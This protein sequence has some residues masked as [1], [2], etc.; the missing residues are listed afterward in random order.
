MMDSWKISTH[1]INSSFDVLDLW[2]FSRK[3]VR[4]QTVNGR[5]VKLNKFESRLNSREL[6]NHCVKLSP[7]HVYMSVLNWL[8][9]ERVGRKTK[10]NYAVPIGGE[11]VI[12]VDSHVIHRYHRHDCS[13]LWG[14]CR[15]C[16]EISKALTISACDTIEWYYSKIA[17]V[18]SGKRGFHIHVLDFDYRD[19]TNFNERDPIKTHE[20]ARYRFSKVISLQTYVFDRAHFTL[21]VDPVGVISVP[22]SLNGETGLV[23]SYIGDKGDLELQTVDNILVKSQ[24]IGKIYGYPEPYERDPPNTSESWEGDEILRKK[25]WGNSGRVTPMTPQLQRFFNNYI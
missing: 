23:C 13:Q 14:V 1:Y 12:D 20:S 3:H 7:L 11:Y 17:I 6:K 4:L 25:S 21:S 5:F 24:S 8:F 18:F 16:I 2:N 19:W 22:N 15:D 10:A 9:P